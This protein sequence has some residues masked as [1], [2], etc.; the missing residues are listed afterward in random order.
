MT[1]LYLTERRLDEGNYGNCIYLIKFSV[2][3]LGSKASDLPEAKFKR[4][5]TN[6]GSTRSFIC[7]LQCLFLIDLKK[8]DYFESAS[9]NLEI[10]HLKASS[11]RRKQKHSWPGERVEYIKNQLQRIRLM[12]VQRSQELRSTAMYRSFR[13]VT[14]GEAKKMGLNDTSS[15]S[16]ACFVPQAKI[17]FW[18]LT[19][20]RSIRWQKYWPCSVFCEITVLDFTLLHI[21]KMQKYHL[22][23]T[24]LVSSFVNQS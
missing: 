4:N 23:R 13:K 3:T 8:R 1:V 2:Q 14:P 7:L 16:I 11:N 9:A 6:S 21:K 24:S 20:V 15:I 10:D 17:L 12:I 5:I 19:I 18:P 22:H